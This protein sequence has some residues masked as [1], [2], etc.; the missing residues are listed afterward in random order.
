VSV[1]ARPVLRP[2]LLSKCATNKSHPRKKLRPRTTTKRSM[3]GLGLAMVAGSR[4]GRLGAPLCGAGRSAMTFIT[5]DGEEG[6]LVHHEAKAVLIDYSEFAVGVRATA[7]ALLGSVI[8]EGQFAEKTVRPPRSSTT[9]S[10][11]RTFTSPS[12]TTNISSPRWPAWKMVAPAGYSRTGST[13]EHGMRKFHLEYHLITRKIVAAIG[14]R[15]MLSTMNL[16]VQELLPFAAAV[17]VYLAYFAVRSSSRLRCEF[18][19]PRSPWSLLRSLHSLRFNKSVHSFLSRVP[20]ASRSSPLHFAPSPFRSR[21]VPQGHPK[22]APPVSTVGTLPQTPTS[23][24]RGERIPPSQCPF[25][26]SLAALASSHHSTNPLWG[27]SPIFQISNPKSELPSALRPSP[28]RT[29]YPRTSTWPGFMDLR[30]V[31]STGG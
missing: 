4:R 17:R 30:L 9:S 12:M 21:P 22:I 29:S 2:T 20:C 19:C 11:M 27:G 24:A 14:N 1:G 3:A 31:F 26:P 23:P 16:D 15:S 13:C 28:L 8:D 5:R 10:P 6:D 7:V 18:S 25:L